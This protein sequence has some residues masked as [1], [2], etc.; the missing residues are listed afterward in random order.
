MGKALT[1]AQADFYQQQGFLFPVEVFSQEE[2]QAIFQKYL[3][4]ESAA[5][6]ELQTRFRVKAHL[7][8]PWL[9][10]IIRNERCS[11]PWKTSIGPMV[12]TGVA[13]TVLPES[14]VRPGMIVL[15]EPDLLPPLQRTRIGMIRS[16]GQAPEEIACFADA[17]RQVL[18]VASSR[19]AINEYLP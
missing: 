13:L 17:I 16:P 15:Q 1:Q 7:P 2:A 5:G 10:D 11:T 8:F 18:R 12:F 9:C 4:T 14:A 6:E 19:K 3:E